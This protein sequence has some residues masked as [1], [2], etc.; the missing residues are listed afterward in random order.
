MGYTSAQ[1]NTAYVSDAMPAASLNLY[2]SNDFDFDPL[3][4]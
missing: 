3:L 1:G 4:H 2:T